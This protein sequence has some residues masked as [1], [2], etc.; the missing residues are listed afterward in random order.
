MPRRIASCCS[1]RRQTRPI[2]QVTA[3]LQPVPNCFQPVTDVVHI[4][5]RRGQREQGGAG[6]SDGTGLSVQ[7]NPGDLP[8]PVHSQ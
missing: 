6:L 8:A 7:A 1:N 2:W 3:I 5:P 4:P